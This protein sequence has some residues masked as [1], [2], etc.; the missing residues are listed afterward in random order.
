MRV[1]QVKTI[2]MKCHVS[3]VCQTMNL[4]IELI[5]FEQFIL[6][7]SNHLHQCLTDQTSPNQEDVQYFIF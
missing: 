3:T 7:R 1:F 5:V 4:H 6:L 2:L